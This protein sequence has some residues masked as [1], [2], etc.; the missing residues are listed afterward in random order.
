VNPMQFVLLQPR[1]RQ[2][3]MA[4]VNRIEGPAKE[5]NIHELWSTPPSVQIPAPRC[6][7]NHAPLSIW[8]SPPRAKGQSE[9]LCSRKRNELL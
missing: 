3:Q 9:M 1:S 6:K 4:A 8:P 7:L 2:R 5:S